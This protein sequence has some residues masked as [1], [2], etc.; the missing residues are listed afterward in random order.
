MSENDT[1]QIFLFGNTDFT[2]DMNLSIIKSSINFIKDW[3]KFNELISSWYEPCQNLPKQKNFKIN[4][5]NFG[6]SYQFYVILYY[7]S[8]KFS[9][10]CGYDFGFF[11]I[12]FG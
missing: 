11:F 2:T 7:N 1:N 4:F 6:I 3:K 10:L 8:T 5:S 12:C 9:F